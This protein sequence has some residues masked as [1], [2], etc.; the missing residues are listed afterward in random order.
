[1]FR[2]SLILMTPTF[3]D[4]TILTAEKNIIILTNM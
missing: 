1:M 4:L 3:Y 2:V